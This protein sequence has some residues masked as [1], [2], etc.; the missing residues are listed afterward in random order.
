[1]FIS[2]EGI[3]GSGKSTQI[4]L[5]SEKFEK[6]GLKVIC[7]RE[8]GG[9]LIGEK[10]RNLFLEE[11][12]EIFNPLTEVLLLYSSRKQLDEQIIR[13]NLAEGNIVIADRFYH[14]TIAYQ[15]YGKGVEVGFVE[16]IHEKLN[17]SKPNLSVLID[18]DPQLSRQRISQR[19]PDRMEQ[20]SLEFF[21]RVQ[22]GYKRLEEN[23]K[24]FVSIDGKKT[25]E[26]ISEEIEI[27]IAKKL[28]V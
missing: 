7:V 4:K 3:E 20:E 2:F 17:I 8:P 24:D 23:N 1:M 26:K 13:P 14:A 22:E 11:T 6:K 25:I 19:D 28:N 27:L 5:L 21:S 12:D 18:I 16:Y 15:C 9:T 10:I